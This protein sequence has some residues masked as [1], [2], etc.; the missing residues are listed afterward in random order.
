MSIITPKAHPHYHPVI[1]LPDSIELYDFSHGYDANRKLLT[2]YG[3]GKYNEHRPGM[4]TGDLFE[5]EVRTIHMGIDIGAPVGTPV[6]A[7]DDGRIL[8]QG[9]NSEPYD[10][11]HVMVTEHRD[12]D[13][14]LFWVLLGHLSKDSVAHLPTGSEFNK[15][16]LLG[17][18]GNKSENGGWNPH[19]HIQ[20]TT[21]RPETHDL[22]GVVSIQERQEALKRFPDPRN[23]LGAVYP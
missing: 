11:G 21:E 4:Y 17:W 3:I 8:H 20:L 13:G 9:Y 12:P 10:Y 14:N 18:I 2:P 19:L 5:I 15:G 22:P 23:I 6:F 7:F 16:D 1:R